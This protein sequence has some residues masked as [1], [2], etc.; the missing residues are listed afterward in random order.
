MG[1]LD[2][3]DVKYKIK[4]SRPDG[5]CFY[6]SVCHQLNNNIDHLHLRNIVADSLTD[7]HL[8]LF[9]AV[10]NTNWNIDYFKQ[11]LSQPYLIWADQIEINALMCKFPKL[12][13]IIFDDHYE[14]IN[15]LCVTCRASYI[16]I[17]LR[18]HKVHYDSVILFESDK[19]HIL[20]KLSSKD[21]ILVKP[22]INVLPII[23][24]ILI[25]LIQVVKRE[26]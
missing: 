17:W 5:D 6:H 14:T 23:V 4:S 8:M 22:Q 18:R 11:Q 26:V 19:K 13:F 20:K 25:V 10:N 1:V 7:H 15:K 12:C 16:Y 21:T 3:I 2:Y 9:N 24:F